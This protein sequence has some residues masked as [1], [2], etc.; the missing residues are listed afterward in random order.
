ML[1]VDKMLHVMHAIE[2]DEKRRQAEEFY[3]DVFTAQTYYDAPPVQ[4]LEL[5]ETPNLIGKTTIIPMAP[6]EGV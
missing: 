1:K 6:V 2:S 3:L 4:G 5:D